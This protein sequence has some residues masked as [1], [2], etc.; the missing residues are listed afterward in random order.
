[1][2]TQGSDNTQ[3]GPSYL[4]LFRTKYPEQTKGLSDEVVVD[5][6][7]NTN[8]TFQKIER[9]R[10]QQ[11]VGG[12][13]TEGLAIGRG[14]ER[15]LKS[16]T[17]LVTEGLPALAK[18]IGNVAVTSVTGEEE[19]PFK[20]EENLERYLN[21]I[22]EA[23]RQA[24]AA[25]P[26]FKDITPFG[27]DPLQFLE[28][29]GSY[30][31]EGLGEQIPQLGFGLGVGGSAGFL[32]KQGAKAAAK[33]AGRELTDVEAKRAINKGMLVGT[34]TT[35]GVQNIP[36]TY[37]KLLSEGEDAAL[38]SV[39]VGAFK[40][41]LDVLP[42]M[43][44]LK[45]V[46]GSGMTDAVADSYLKSIGSGFVRSSIQEG[47]TESA[48]ETTDLLAQKFITD[49]PEIFTPE[50]ITGIID[51]GLKGAISGGAFGAGGAALSPEA[52]RAYAEQ[53]SKFSLDKLSPEAR[54]KVE[55]RFA[56]E[57][58]NEAVLKPNF[59][60]VNKA[61]SSI[62]EPVY[63]D[64]EL[65][66]SLNEIGVWLESTSNLSDKDANNLFNN[67]ISPSFNNAVSLDTVYN[68]RFL[69]AENL[70][71]ALTERKNLITS[72]KRIDE[73]NGD[74]NFIPGDGEIL[75]GVNINRDVPTLTNQYGVVRTQEG[76]ESLNLLN[77]AKTQAETPLA[78]TFDPKLNVFPPSLG[79]PKPRF[80]NLEVSFPTDI[81][82]ATY[83]ASKE[84]EK[85]KRADDIKGWL[86]QETGWTDAQIKT[87]GKEIRNQL[88]DQAQQLPR[89]TR[90]GKVIK[91]PSLT[92][93]G[94][95]ISPAAKPQ[96]ING[97][98]FGTLRDDVVTPTVVSNSLRG[99]ELSPKAKEQW[100][101]TI[102]QFQRV[103]K[104]IAGPSVRVE[105]F[106]R[107]STA[108]DPS[109]FALE[110][111]AGAQLMNSVYIALEVR[112]GRPVNETFYHELFHFLYN[113]G[114]YTA[115]EKKVLENS[116]QTLKKYLNEDEYL[117]NHDFQFLESTKE[118]RE[119]LIANAFGKRAKE[120]ED[121]QKVKGLPANIDRLFR[122][123]FNFISRLGNAMRGLGFNTFDD[124]VQKTL[125]GERAV[126]VVD[127]INHANKI[128][129]LQ[130]IS[131]EFQQAHIDENSP[132]KNY[133]Q[134]ISEARKE[135]NSSKKKAG[136]YTKYIRSMIDAASKFPIM[137]PVVESYQR[138]ER[139]TSNILDSMLR[140]LND[141]QRQ[142]KAL[143]YK[144]HELAD[145]MRKTN[146]PPRYDAEG[147]LIY[148]NS[149][150][151]SVR[152]KDPEIGRQFKNMQA[153]YRVAL[154]NFEE[155]LKEVAYN[156]LG[157]RVL[158]NRDFSEGDARRALDLLKL[159][160]EANQLQIDRLEGLIE[161]MAEIKQM[162]KKA[163]VPWMR[164][165]RWGL[166][167]R[168]RSTGEQV[169]FYTVEDGKFKDKFDKFQLEGV[170]EDLQNKY[171]DK[172]KY[173]II[174]ADGEITNLNSLESLDMFLLNRNNIAKNV[175]P[176]MMNIESLAAMLYSKGVD[177]ESYASLKADIIDKI[178]DK[179]FQKRFDPSQGIDGYSKDWDRVQHGYLTGASHFI[180]KTRQQQELSAILT[181][182]DK[183]EDETLKDMVKTY[184]EYNDSPTE[185]LQAVRSFNFMWTMGAN[186]STAVLQLFTLPTST[187][188]ALTQYNPNPIENMR[189]IGKWFNL[190]FEFFPDIMKTVQTHNGLFYADFANMDIAKRLKEEGKLTDEHIQFLFKTAVQFRGFLTEE[191]SGFKPFETRSLGGTINA[192]LSNMANTLGVPISMMEQLTR[193][194]TT[195]AAFDT[196]NSNPQARQRA[197]KVLKNDHR[198]KA[199][200]A[201]SKDLN[202]VE[203]IALF[204]M[205]EAH[206]VFGK[207][208]RPG[209]FKGFGG[210]F[211]LPFMTYP[212]Q[213][214][215][216]M[217]RMYGRGAE[218]K[219][220]LATTLGALFFF[221]GLMGLPG[222]EL[223]KELLEE[224]EKQVTGTEEDFDLLLREK[225]GEVTDSPQF[226]K[227]V[228]QGIGRGFLDLD[229]ARRIGLPI[230]GQDLL[231][232]AL[233]TRGPAA[234][235]DYLGVAG[236]LMEG[237][238]TA[239]Q[240]YNTG[241]SMGNVI[242]NVLPVVP[243]NIVKAIQ[244]GESGVTT[245][246]GT[247]LLTPEEVTARTRALRAFGVT[248][249]QVADRRDE[250]WLRLLS[251]RKYTPGIEKFRTQAKRV[252]TERARAKLDQDWDKVRELD[253]EYNEVLNK[254][255]DF[256]IMNGI[257]FDA[258][259][260]NRSVGKAV[261]QRMTATFS[262][263]E[264]RKAGR[265]D[266]V[267]AREPLGFLREDEQ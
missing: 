92:K 55:E 89:G 196:V 147:R 186:P 248:S 9:G 4:E 81:E 267:Q 148:T 121:Q 235:T 38:T 53:G 123:G 42:Q 230:P 44:I 104:E 169:A 115:Q 247:Q 217:F 2:S 49:N 37:F 242:S 112:N 76:V 176:R 8:P 173:K 251:N 184:I 96:R 151:Q 203:N 229:V 179:G 139:N 221:S 249:G 110:P 125:N 211:L 234:T 165:G 134:Y 11:M 70:T 10:F 190:S 54:A 86:Q 60:K 68:S 177:E 240:E 207:V 171:S 154:D 93:D 174:G 200:L 51:A 233:G 214:L 162:R 57:T 46:A 5:A 77:R 78:E 158:G 20:P 30:I 254:L 172:S 163:F 106:A 69:E 74:V 22:E 220:A 164:F 210:A 223:L 45:K 12:R 108:Q 97:P 120:L 99:I 28:D 119:E 226:A 232:S 80:Q 35:S 64:P 105:P 206:A 178:L 237:M 29:T 63:L 65:K 41:G 225:I 17:A 192:Q 144:L 98:L 255:Q 156:F 187:L 161:R 33:R 199:Q 18:G 82:K 170:L 132:L 136:F 213:V 116:L 100:Q 107:L 102:N 109:K 83:I 59:N 21:K 118:G 149:E 124:I 14:L 257:P 239:W 183:L 137:G 142:P 258:P 180:A 7:R 66:K 85:S 218:G 215:E 90:K 140:A 19:G 31:A 250:L 61:D 26:S 114:A 1:M 155:V 88:K 262:P 209:M 216:F 129:R 153:G 101:E 62:T 130:R 157:P 159:D 71:Q 193:F 34:T 127:D 150:G 175:D 25:I 208:G 79:K 243:S 259:A 94:V 91:A 138:R 133:K 182:V 24:P 202:V 189:T 122:K 146:Q 185:D 58:I 166:T 145:F 181:E 168:D 188:G 231:M 152:I 36:E 252:A 224:V 48:Q 205:D 117:R 256:V 103:A 13:V 128:A 246:S 201:N 253:E 194:A 204:T 236:S 219:K 195:M 160:E 135:Q 50:A 241:G 167:V 261:N 191:Y 222:F 52:R 198:F 266:F 15:G 227:F 238:G 212:Q 264:V 6:I 47:V 43:E 32:A 265:A 95:A 72:G 113:N 39:L 143:R 87:I 3:Q 260:F 27:E 23:Q 56:T 244:M 131:E 75:T 84:G 197:L 228:T 111:V 73:L 126:D 16:S 245:K 40:T 67:L 263:Q 141:F